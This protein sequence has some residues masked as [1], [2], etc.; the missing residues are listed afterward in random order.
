MPESGGGGEHLRPHLGDRLVGE[1]DPAVDDG[2]ARGPEETFRADVVLVVEGG[3][4]RRACRDPPRV[5]RWGSSTPGPEG[6]G[7]SPRR[8]APGSWPPGRRRRTTSR[9]GRGGRGPSGPTAPRRPRAS[10]GAG[11]ARRRARRS[12]VRTAC[13]RRIWTRTR[14]ARV[15]GT[16]TPGGPEELLQDVQWRVPG[17]DG[18]EAHFFRVQGDQPGVPDD[19]DVGVGE[20]GHTVHAAAG[21]A[22][23]ARDLVAVGRALVEALDVHHA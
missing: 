5:V 15:R 7:G 9:A 18:A 8:P 23:R 11:R 17:A 22:H 21:Q 20:H 19:G 13:A 14:W 3:R 6:A 12:R 16:A 1:S 10:G 2:G 4:F